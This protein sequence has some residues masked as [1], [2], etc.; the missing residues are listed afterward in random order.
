MQ[1]YDPKNW[2]LVLGGNLITG[3]GDNTFISI[4]K[5]SEA[6]EDAAGV[7]GEVVRGRKHDERATLEITLMRTSASN[8][9][10]SDMYNLGRQSANGEDIF[11]ARLV[12]REGSSEHKAAEA[13]VQDAPAVSLEGGPNTT[14]WKVRL[15]K[16][17]ENHAD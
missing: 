14:T 4:T 1:T 3:W 17:K 12:N 8:Q 13:W 6:Y 7:D 2:D 15:A 16:Y 11:S 5:E 9:I 10:L